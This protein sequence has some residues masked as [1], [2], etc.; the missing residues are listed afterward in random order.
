MC[1]DF[2]HIMLS[3]EITSLPRDRFMLKQILKLQSF[4]VKP[5]VDETLL[6]NNYCIQLHPHNKAAHT[7]APRVMLRGFLRC[8][9]PSSLTPLFIQNSVF[10][11]HGKKSYQQ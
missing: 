3:L 5:I 9:F 1:N 8:D 4:K 6:E 2:I 10:C 11:Y 7:L